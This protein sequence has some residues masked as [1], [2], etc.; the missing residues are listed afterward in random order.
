MDSQNTPDS[1]ANVKRGKKNGVNG[2]PL[3][4]TILQSC[5]N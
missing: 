4:Q 2:G 1:E 3:F 5:S